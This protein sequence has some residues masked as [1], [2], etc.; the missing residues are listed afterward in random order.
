MIETNTGDAASLFT[1]E[2]PIQ[3]D[4]PNGEPLACPAGTR[5]AAYKTIGGDGKLVS[6]RWVVMVLLHA[7]DQETA[8]SKA[9]LLRKVA[10][11]EGGSACSRN[12]TSFHRA[13]LA[14]TSKSWLRWAGPFA[15]EDAAFSSRR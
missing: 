10:R 9:S 5:F 2:A 11:A 13:D 3:V 7:G 12:R 8:E 1:T 14:V 15:A 6:H 4:M